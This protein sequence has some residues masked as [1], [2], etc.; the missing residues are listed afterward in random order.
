M[1]TG[2]EGLVRWR[3]FDSMISPMEFIPLAEETGMIISLDRLVFEMACNEIGALN[4]NRQEP[5]TVALNCS[6]RELYSTNYTDGLA[7]ILVKTGMRPEWLEIEIT[8]TEL[9]K[10]LDISLSVL[11]K[12]A[13][14]GISIA[15]DDFGTGYSSLGQLTRLPINTL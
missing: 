13:D 9:M 7:E 5:L 10:D 1:I 8:E 14:M 4:K 6:A 2:S 11:R 3:F 15:L 12:L